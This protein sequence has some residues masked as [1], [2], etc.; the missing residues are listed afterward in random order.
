MLND[1]NNLTVN[2]RKLEENEKHLIV[3]KVKTSNTINMRK[4]IADAMGEKIENFMV[5]ELIK[6]EKEIFINLR[7]IIK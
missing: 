5:P 3:D 6:S 2:G 4:I 7:S 1:L